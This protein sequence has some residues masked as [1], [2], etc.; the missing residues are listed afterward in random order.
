M[1]LTGSISDETVEEM[2]E[3]GVNDC[4]YKPFQQKDLFE[5]IKK[6]LPSV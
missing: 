5:M 6:I 1:V 2:K 3:A 4:L